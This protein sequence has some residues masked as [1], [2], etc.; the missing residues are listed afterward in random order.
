MFRCGTSNDT[1]ENRFGLKKVD[2]NNINTTLVFPKLLLRKAL[3]LHFAVN[4]EVDKIS[5]WCTDI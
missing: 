2:P 4:D 5:V 3:V 1:E